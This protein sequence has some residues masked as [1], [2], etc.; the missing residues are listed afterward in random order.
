MLLAAVRL[1]VVAGD[2]CAM[3]MLARRVTGELPA[4]A[5]RRQHSVVRQLEQT[6]LPG[7]VDQIADG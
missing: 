1:T 5:P 2:L 3:D 7:R 6:F 4:A